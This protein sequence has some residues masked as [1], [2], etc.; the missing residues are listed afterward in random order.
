[1]EACAIKRVLKPSNRTDQTEDWFETEGD[2]ITVAGVAPLEVRRAQR[3][4]W[5]ICL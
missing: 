5:F 4:D 3:R 1:M 2:S